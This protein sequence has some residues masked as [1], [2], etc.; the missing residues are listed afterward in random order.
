MMRQAWIAIMLAVMLPGQGCSR[1]D[2]PG[3]AVSKADKTRTV[4]TL[5]VRLSDGFQDSTVSVAVDG[6]QVFHQSGV[7]TDQRIAHAASCEVQTEADSVQLEV[8][9]EGG[10]RAVLAVA[11]AETPFVEVSLVDGALQLTPRN[12]ATPMY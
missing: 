12:Q 1:H 3:A 10:P 6:A 5:H 7:S 8:A 4:M 9:V 2:L 11:P